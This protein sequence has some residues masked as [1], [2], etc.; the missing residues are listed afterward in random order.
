MDNRGL[1]YCGRTQIRILLADDHQ[2]VRQQMRLRLGHELDFQVVAEASNSPQVVE[3]A[4]ALKP[5][6]ALIDPMMRDGLGLETVGWM[7]NH[8]P[9]TAIVVLTAVVDTALKMELKKMGVS[10]ILNKGIA[11]TELIGILRDVK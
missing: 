5:Q 2:N 6:I 11:S 1:D 4:W 8:V 3:R 9:E 10:R 7:A